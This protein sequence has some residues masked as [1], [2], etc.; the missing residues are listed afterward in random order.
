M[1]LSEKA[2]VDAV[3]DWSLEYKTL[4]IRSSV[5][6]KYTSV[7][8]ILGDEYSVDIRSM[9]SDFCLFLEKGIRCTANAQDF[10]TLDALLIEVH[11]VV[12]G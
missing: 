6:E 9:D 10:A 8:F 1:R 5:H 3:R 4:D 7:S 12:H 2:L 11:H